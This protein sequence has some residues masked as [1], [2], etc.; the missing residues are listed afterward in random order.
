MC[1][2]RVLDTASKPL[3]PHLN[4]MFISLASYLVPHVSQSQT[5]STQVYPALT[6]PCRKKNCLRGFRQSEFQTS[7]LSYRDLSLKFEIS[8]AASLHIILSKKQ[9]TKALIRLPRCG[10]W[11]APVLFTNPRRQVFSRRGLTN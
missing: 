5:P 7:L 4:L 3:A 8:H 1:V 2:Q 11:S 10:G 9:R 6:G